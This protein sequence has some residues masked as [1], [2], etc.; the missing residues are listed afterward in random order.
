LTA[1]PVWAL[2]E[3]AAGLNPEIETELYEYDLS[4]EVRRRPL[5]LRREN[6]VPYD[7]GYHR[8]LAVR[9]AELV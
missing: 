3:L 6:L 2:A 4:G 8:R 9:A 7:D 5:I 1:V